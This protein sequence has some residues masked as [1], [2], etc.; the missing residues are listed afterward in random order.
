MWTCAYKHMTSFALLF[1]KIPQSFSVPNQRGQLPFN[2]IKQHGNEFFYGSVNKDEAGKCQ[3]VGEGGDD[4]VGSNSLNSEGCDVVGRDGGV[5]SDVFNGN[6][7]D[8]H[9]A[10]FQIAE[11]SK[12]LLESL[13]NE[14][15]EDNCDLIKDINFINMNNNS[16]NTNNNNNKNNKNK[17]EL[18]KRFSLTEDGLNYM[19]ESNV[20][21]V[22]NVMNYKPHNA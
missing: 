22:H 1:Q 11:S 21:F 7:V 10:S 4:I 15:S 5:V 17:R 19:L 14:N 2:Y 12:T 9:M 16:T 13:N 6:L 20:M 3:R 18:L 8:G